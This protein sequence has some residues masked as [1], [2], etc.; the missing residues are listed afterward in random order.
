M[1]F[2]FTKNIGATPGVIPAENPQLKIKHLEEFPQKIS[3]ATFSQ[4]NSLQRVPEGSFEKKI[5]EEEFPGKLVGT[6]G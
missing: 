5:N 6:V 2:F 4:P 1:C 3:A